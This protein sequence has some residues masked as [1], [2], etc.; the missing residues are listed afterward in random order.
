MQIK[1][2]YI[3][4]LTNIH[5]PLTRLVYPS[6]VLMPTAQFSAAANILQERCNNV[7]QQPLPEH[8]PIKRT[9]V[10]RLVLIWQKDG[11]Y[12]VRIRY[13]S[14]TWCASATEADAQKSNETPLPLDHRCIYPVSF[15]ITV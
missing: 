6:R 2:W 4:T 8:L 11:T 1:G 14:E 12:S 5:I 15:L 9:L 7:V 13:N 10:S 3:F